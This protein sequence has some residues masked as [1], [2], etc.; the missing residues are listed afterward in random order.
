VHQH[1]PNCGLYAKV[2]ITTSQWNN[3]YRMMRVDAD[4]VVISL[5]SND[6]KGINTELQLRKLRKRVDANTVIWIIPSGV[7]KSSGIN[8][9]EI[10]KI[11]RRVA[12]DYDDMTVMIPELSKDRIHP[13]TR[14]YNKLGDMIK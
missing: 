11:V 10:Q 12:R 7:G 2:G 4:K 6:Y 1:A 13:T 3:T 8:I 5:G 9:T 14:G